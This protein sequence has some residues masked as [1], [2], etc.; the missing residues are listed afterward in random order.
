VRLQIGPEKINS[1]KRYG[2]L[3]TLLLTLFAGCQTAPPDVT[4]N[5]D[6][7]TGSRTD[8]MSEN[9][10]ETTQNPPREVVWLNASRLDSSYWKRKGA[11]YLE[12]MYQALTDTGYLDIPFGTTLL[13]NVD[14][15]EMGFTG[16]GSYNKRKSSK[17]GY[18]IESALYEVKR[19]ELEAIANAKHV[20]VKIKGNNGI[21][22]REFSP[23]NFERFRQFLARA[24]A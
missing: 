1:M 10:L 4:T 22:E 9:I 17:K 11:F 24:R 13:L 19:P 3:S 8:L 5:F 7:I 12:V 16:N 23:E 20:K 14:G 2:I 6:P 21:V 18:V 15:K